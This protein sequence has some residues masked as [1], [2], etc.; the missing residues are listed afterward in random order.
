[1]RP[2]RMTLPVGVRRAILAHARRDA[3]REC[4]GFLI[5]RRGR[6]LHAAVMRNA[7]ARSRVQFRID[8]AE[9]ISL[10]RE[11]RRLSPALEIVGIYHSHPAGPPE[12]SDQDRREA[13]Y[14]EWLYVIA[15]GESDKFR[16][17]AYRIDRRTPRTR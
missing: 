9:H 5:G 12:P 1:M 11:L 2:S 16:L 17:R 8:P 3:P 6:V 14:R 15:I 13:H 7:A 10:R 4:C